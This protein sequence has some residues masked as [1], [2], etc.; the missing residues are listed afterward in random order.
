MTPVFSRFRVLSR[1]SLAALSLAPLSVAA[2]DGRLEVTDENLG[3]AAGTSNQAGSGGASG[4][5]GPS[6]SAGTAGTAGAG[7][8]SASCNDG[9]RN[10]D[11]TAVDCGGSSCPECATE[12][13]CT[14]GPVECDSTICV[15]GVCQPPTCQD[16]V[17]NGD[18]AGVDCGGTSPCGP[19]LTLCHEQ[20]AVSDVMIPL[21]CDPN[22]PAP[23][24]VASQ[25]RSNDD[26]SLIAF[27]YCYEDARCTPMYWS[28]SAGVRALTVSG[29]GTLTGMSADGQLV[30]V[31]PQVALGGQS[32]LFTPDGNST[33]SGLGPTPGLISADGTLVGVSPTTKNAFA[34]LRRPRGG[35]VEPLG[36]L[37]FGVNQFA[38][39]GAAADASVIIGYSYQEGFQPFRYT[40]AGGLVFGLEGLP[41]TAD[42]AT[43]SALSRDG[44]TFAG[45]TLLGNERH[46]VFRW[47]QA[48]GVL[49]IAPVTAPTPGVDPAAMSLSDD[50]S[51][52]VFSR[53]TNAAT[54]DFSAYRWTTQNGSEALTPGIQST[55][56]LV[57]GDGSVI[58]GQTLDSS[59]Y[60]SFIWTPTGGARSIRSALE[61]AGVDLSGWSIDTP[62]SLS[63]DGKVAMGV[64]RCG[65]ITTVYRLV[66]PD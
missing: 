8:D 21:G 42:G 37:P 5:G 9:V 15:D 63:R 32:L 16:G 57:S 50:G 51:V 26:G 55:A 10:G 33:P 30:L 48:D 34:L 4:S 41:D 17:R 39:S 20:C 35:E 25:P 13:P 7:G 62:W 22:A 58:I 44:Q 65:E 53:E 23:F 28:A 60:R 24:G 49:E 45:V 12:G 64:G 11:E 52:L 19:C 61:G 46:N 6:G 54:G 47:T 27:D 40:E 43:I 2:C 56:A 29:G 1:G 14:N 31:S 38:L 59:D 66:L 3:G 18:E 36:D